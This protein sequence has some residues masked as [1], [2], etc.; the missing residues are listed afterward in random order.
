[1]RSRSPSIRFVVLG[2]THYTKVKYHRHPLRTHKTELI[3]AA[4][5]YEGMLT[6]VL[7]PI[8]SEI[9]QHNPDFI[10]QVG[11]FVNGFIEDR[12][13]AEEEMK[14]ALNYFSLLHLPFFIVKGNHETMV[15]KVGNRAYHDIVLPFLS[16]QLGHTLKRN[17]Y[18]FDKGNAHFVIVDSFQFTKSQCKWLENELETSEQRH[19]FVFSHS[20]LIQVARPFFISRQFV[21]LAAPLFKRNHIDTL[22]CAHTHNQSAVL[23]KF[24]KNNLLQ[25][26]TCPLGTLAKEPTPLEEKKKLLISSSDLEY[27]WG[28]DGDNTPSWVLVEVN[29][30][31]VK[32]EWHL[33]RKGACR[34]FE[35]KKEKGKIKEIKKPKEKKKTTLKLSDLQ[36]IQVGRLYLSIYNS[37][38]INKSLFLNKRKIGYIPVGD[39]YG[40]V[41]V[42]IPKAV[43][44]TI[45]PVNKLEIKN[46]KGEH[47]CAGSFY[48]EVILKDNRKVKTD[49]APYIY[50]TSTR[51]NDQDIKCVRYINPKRKLPVIFLRFSISKK[52]L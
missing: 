14:D 16:N 51:W 1:M 50:T 7:T 22:F 40:T 18:S 28:Y 43:L 39:A 52:R 27:Y 20:P 49:I 25:L 6:N 48:L 19:I 4:K 37:H 15:S 36:R 38:T 8:L 42:E 26:M 13:S 35:W 23:S 46:P 31:K 30:E 44:P 17:Y 24:G 2:D 41:K 32:I 10:I 21:K 29:E 34:I 3:E 47:F 9:K 5:E 45:K 12:K 33:L 11:D